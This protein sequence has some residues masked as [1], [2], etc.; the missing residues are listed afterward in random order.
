VTVGVAVGITVAV[1]VGVGIGVWVAVRVG[2]A[3]TRSAGDAVNSSTEVGAKATVAGGDAD[4]GRRKAR[5][6]I[7]PVAL[8]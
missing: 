2:L 6:G 4:D 7:S 3:L 5:P 8:N 1:A